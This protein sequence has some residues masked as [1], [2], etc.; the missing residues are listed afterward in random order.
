MQE[1][2]G[3]HG[4]QR[5]ETQ[6]RVIRFAAPAVLVFGT[7]IDQ[8]Q[9]PRRRQALD[10]R[11]EQGLRLSIDP[12]QVFADQQQR[13]HLA[14]AHEHALERLQGTPAPLWRLEGE[15]RMVL[16][17][18]LQEPEE[19]RDGLLERLVQGQHLPRHPGPDGAGVVAV[20]HLRIALQQVEHWKI[21]VALP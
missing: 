4:W 14:F 20:L 5:V 8:E 21:G 19:R 3:T 9:E 10:Q 15:K 16:R 7:V 11:I 18:G 2:L 13:L 17:Q 12:V 1:C 6:L